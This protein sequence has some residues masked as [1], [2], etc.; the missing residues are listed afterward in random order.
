M[1]SNGWVLT[2]K[3]GSGGF[4]MFDSLCDTYRW[5]PVTG[6][7]NIWTGRTDSSD[8]QTKMDYPGVSIVVG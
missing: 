1:L 6:L 4:E 8:A 3:S 2:R 7:D 5:W